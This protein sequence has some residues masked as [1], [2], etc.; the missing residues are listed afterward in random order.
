ML[1]T[2]IFNTAGSM[3]YLH[4]RSMLYAKKPRGLLEQDHSNLPPT[5]TTLLEVEE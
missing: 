1:Q 3:L 5:A 2:E 4:V